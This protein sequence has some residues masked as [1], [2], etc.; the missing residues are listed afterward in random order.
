MSRENN[1]GM[2]RDWGFAGAQPQ[3]VMPTFA[4]K[5]YIITEILFIWQ[6][7]L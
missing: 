1:H 7:P 6:C 3:Q 4:W 2:N 5:H